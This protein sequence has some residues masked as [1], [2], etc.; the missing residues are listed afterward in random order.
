MLLLGFPANSSLGARRRPRVSEGSYCIFRNLNNTIT[1]ERDLFK[2]V[3]HFV[4][5]MPSILQSKHPQYWLHYKTSLC[6]KYRVCVWVW[7]CTYTHGFLFFVHWFNLW[8]KLSNW[9]NT[10]GSW[11]RRLTC[12]LPLQF[13]SNLQTLW[14]INNEIRDKKE[15]VELSQPCWDMLIVFILLKTIVCTQLSSWLILLEQY[16]FVSEGPAEHIFNAGF[17][18]LF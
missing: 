2:K 3:A 13:K 16:M 4:E 11:R 8:R 14:N 5:N 6:P 10:G 15:V 1:R 17:S 7:V 12:P 9:N 18:L